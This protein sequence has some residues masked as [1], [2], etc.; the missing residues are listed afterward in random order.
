[1]LLIDRLLTL[2][3]IEEFKEIPGDLLT[4][5]IEKLEEIRVK[6]GSMIIR[7]GDKGSEPLYI[8]LHG[9][10]DI[11][12]GDK[13]VEEKQ[14]DDVFGEKLVNETDYFEYTALARTVCTVLVLKKEELLN[15]MSAHIEL[16][17]C[18]LDII[19]DERKSDEQ[20]EIVDA[21]FA[22]A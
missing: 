1:L 13:L 2:K 11:Y 16:L 15:L 17:E 9:I 8:V 4:Y 14:T 22:S 21:L 19:N 20:L 18:W 7:E 10:V 12:D 3:R 6:P 5:L